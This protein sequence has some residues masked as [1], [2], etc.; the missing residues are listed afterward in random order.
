M[1]RP[2][3]DRNAS[4]RAPNGNAAAITAEVVVAVTGVVDFSVSIDPPSSKATHYAVATAITNGGS[5]CRQTSALRGKRRVELSSTRTHRGRFAQS[6]TT[7]LTVRALRTRRFGRTIEREFSVGGRRPLSDAPG[8]RNSRDQ[9]I[10]P[11]ALIL[12]RF[13]CWCSDCRRRLRCD[14]GDDDIS[15]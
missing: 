5:A 8:R 15:P 9:P 14:R 2:C 12:F 1:G 7:A 3:R 4:V 13:S 11:M 10:V 6:V